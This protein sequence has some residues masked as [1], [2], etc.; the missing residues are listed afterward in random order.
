MPTPEQTDALY[1]VLGAARALMAAQLRH[2][3]ANIRALAAIAVD[4]DIAGAKAT[5]VAAALELDFEDAL[6]R[7]RDALFQTR[8]LL[9]R[10]PPARGEQEG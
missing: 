4:P 7:L 5:D 3:R 2:E 9:L 1:D 8:A 10:E 6:Q